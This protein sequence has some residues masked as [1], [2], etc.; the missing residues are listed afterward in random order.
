MPCQREVLRDIK[1]KMQHEK[2]H[3]AWRAEK[4][5][6]DIGAF[7][8]PCSNEK[9]KWQKHR[10]AEVQKA[11]VSQQPGGIKPYG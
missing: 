3:L 10:G 4:R 8:M 7:S 1:R 2:M 11:A 5:K 6:S 9:T